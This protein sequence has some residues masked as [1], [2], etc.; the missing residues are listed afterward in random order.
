M[1][2]KTQRYLLILAT[3]ST[4]SLVILASINIGYTVDYISR[5]NQPK[6]KLTEKD[7][8]KNHYY[9]MKFLD[10]SGQWDKLEKS[11]RKR[12]ETYPN[13][14]K[15]RMYLGMALFG[16]KRWKESKNIFDT[17]RPETPRQR[18]SIDMYL[19]HIESQLEVQNKKMQVTN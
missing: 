8:Y 19:E 7:K 9:D 10:T 14:T 16:Q 12:L 1:T 18:T 2:D 4:A 17:L 15:G 3:I 6:K 11:A 5:R 13:D